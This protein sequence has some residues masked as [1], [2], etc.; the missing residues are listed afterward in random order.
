M[1]NETITKPVYD[2]YEI[3][4]CIERYAAQSPGFTEQC[5]DDEAQFWT[6]Y[7]HIPGQGVETIGDFKSREAAEECFYRITGQAFGGAI[8]SWK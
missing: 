6:L 8:P 7:G 5:P 2:N 1:T 4:G 3:H